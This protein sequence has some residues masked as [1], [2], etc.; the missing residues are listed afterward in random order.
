MKRGFTLIEVMIVIAIIFLLAAIAIP[1]LIRAR[2]PSAQ[3]TIEAEKAL[4]TI[5]LK[6][7]PDMKYPCPELAGRPLNIAVDDSSNMFLAYFDNDGFLK[8][9][10]YEPGYAMYSQTVEFVK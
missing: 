3:A 10:R 8:V 1:Q 4:N 2:N 5:K 9:K 6:V 7:P